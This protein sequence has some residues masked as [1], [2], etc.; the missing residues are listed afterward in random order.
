MA[1]AAGREL[2]RILGIEVVFSDDL[3]IGRDWLVVQPRTTGS[4]QLACFGAA[5]GKTG[6][7]E[8]LEGRDAGGEARAR[9]ADGRQRVGPD[10]FLKGTPSRLGGCLRG[11]PAMCESRHLG[12]EDLLG[13]VDLLAGEALQPRDL[14]KRQVGEDAQEAASKTT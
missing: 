4:D 1:L 13:L 7:M 5:G 6:F 8:Q 9:Q 3:R 12:G 2:E 10:T 14:V 11:L